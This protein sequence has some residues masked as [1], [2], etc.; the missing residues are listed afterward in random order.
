MKIINTYSK[1]ILTIVLT[2]AFIA[3]IPS[4][5]GESVSNRRFLVDFGSAL[6]T[7]PES[8]DGLDDLVWNNLT[9]GKT[10]SSING[11]KDCLGNVST[12]NLSLTDGFWDK[13][14]NVSNIRG[15]KTSSIYPPSATRD[16]FFIGK[17]D[18]YEDGSARLHLEGLNRAA[19]YTIRIYASRMTEDLESDRTTLYIINGVVKSLQVRNN[20][21][22]Y[23]EFSDLNPKGG[24]IDIGV[25]LTENSIFGYL[26]VV[27]VIENIPPMISITQPLPVLTSDSSGI[28]EL[29][30]TAPA[31][32]T[33]SA[34]ASDK[35]GQI[36][37][38]SFFAD[39]NLLA[40]VKSAPYT[41]AWSNVPVGS[42]TLR[43]V[44]TDDS[45][46]KT[47]SQFVHV[48]VKAKPNVLPTANAGADQSIK[49]PRNTITLNGSGL[50]ADGKIVGY[51]WTGTGGTISN[52]NDASTIVTGL[53][54]GTF[55][56]NLEV[57]DDRGGKASDSVSVTVAK[58]NVAPTV[59][60]GADQSI[61]L[62]ANSVT[63]TG[64]AV[65]SDGT[66]QKYSW[67]KISGGA[68][69]IQSSKLFQTVVSGLVEGVYTF[70]LEVTDNEG[71]K[72]SDSVVVT[73]KPQPVTPKPVST[74]Q[75]DAGHV[76][77]LHQPSNYTSM[78]TRLNGSVITK[79][80]KVQNYRWTQIS[81]APARIETPNSSSTTVTG[82]TPGNYV[83]QL[84]I[85]DKMDRYGV[86][87]VTVNVLFEP[88]VKIYTKGYGQ[89]RENGYVEYLP[90]NY[91]SSTTQKWP[92]MIFLHGVNQTNIVDNNGNSLNLL[93]VG[94]AGPL[95][96]ARSKDANGK[97][98]KLPFIL[99]SPQ[100]KGWWTATELEQFRQ[101]VIKKY[102]VDTTRF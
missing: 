53:T 88:N 4:L 87:T 3:L 57:T 18:G 41:Y 75:I 73:V 61:V 5:Q 89:N 85:T 43:A 23:V 10:G 13:A 19:V 40:T 78:S 99:L 100:S 58:A 65:D 31:S 74:L 71:S 28:S 68:A 96:F 98:H 90:E 59:K 6:Y 80:A 37:E 101:D 42:Y 24:V 27:E 62:P 55:T 21:D 72:A 9:S 26:G 69:I 67:T 97:Y 66:I 44:A 93:T 2:A 35:D 64:S 56:F 39:N 34:N 46:F 60:A 7:S 32:I 16:S 12:I 1:S 77:T 92:L 94:D 22:H 15:T 47:R 54:A 11:L 86:D 25:G 81:G 29:V 50:D 52:P 95:N 83:F 51:H 79:G 36:T 48:T 38:V 102:R 17:Y 8:K 63:L 14:D 76:G 84:E 70:Q 33:I 30:Y 82:L 45:G 20:I 91:S 49:L